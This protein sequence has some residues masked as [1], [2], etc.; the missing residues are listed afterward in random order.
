MRR[1]RERFFQIAVKYLAQVRAHRWI[2]GTPKTCPSEA[3]TFDIV[4]DQRRIAQRLVAAIL[5]DGSALRMA[6]LMTGAR[7]SRGDCAVL[8]KDF[9]FVP[10]AAVL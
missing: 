1:T 2:N 5:R 8:G 9:A 3:E 7:V 6:C 10:M 4:I